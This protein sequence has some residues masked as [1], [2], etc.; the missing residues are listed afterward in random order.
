[1]FETSAMVQLHKIRE[2]MYEE[3]KSMSDEEFIEYIRKEAEKVEEEIKKLREKAKKEM[4][5]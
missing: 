1:M 3:T 2:Q 5:Q 4:V